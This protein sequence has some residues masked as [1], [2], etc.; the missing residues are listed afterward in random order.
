[1]KPY[2]PYKPYLYSAVG[3]IIRALFSY[4]TTESGETITTEAGDKLV[5]E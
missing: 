5:I 1:M 3:S 4:L 2:L